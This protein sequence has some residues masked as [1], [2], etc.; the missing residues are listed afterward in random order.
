MAEGIGIFAIGPQA[1]LWR[2]AS[3]CLIESNYSTCLIG[4]M[5]LLQPLTEQVRQA[6][7]MHIVAVDS[8]DC[9]NIVTRYLGLV[10]ECL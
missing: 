5:I 10:S 3:S 6:T 1:L 9:P 4:S 8:G 2:R 7:V